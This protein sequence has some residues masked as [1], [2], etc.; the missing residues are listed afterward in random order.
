VFVSDIKSFDLIAMTPIVT[1]CN[2]AHVPLEAD[3]ID[4]A[5]FCLSLMGTDWPDFIREGHRVLKQ[6]K[7]LKIAEVQSRFVDLQR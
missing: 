7:L 1:A 3:S 4:V 2:I 6:G 5:V